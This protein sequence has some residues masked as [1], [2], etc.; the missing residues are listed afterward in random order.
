[1]GAFLYYRNPRNRPDKGW[2]ALQPETGTVVEGRT[3]FDLQTQVRAYRTANALPLEPNFERQLHG[4]VCAALP[5]GER[6]RRCK[7]EGDGGALPR[8]L[9]SWRTSKGVLYGWAVAAMQVV[10]QVLST[11]V[12]KKSILVDAQTAQERG[13][14]CAMCPENLPVASCWGCG[15]LGS[16][17]RALRGRASVSTEN[18]PALETCDVCGCSN[19]LQTHF[20]IDLLEKIRK[21][22]GLPENPYPRWCWKRTEP[23]QPQPTP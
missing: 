9:R 20:N 11:T 12:D 4:Q 14:I 5:Q 17:M 23:P 6:S 21:A 1:M 8:H 16:A 10:E 15:A 7:F 2:K 3:W 22:Q 18:G 19:E 13:R